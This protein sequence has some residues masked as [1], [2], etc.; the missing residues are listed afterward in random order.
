MLRFTPKGLSFII[1]VTPEEEKYRTFQI[2]KKDGG[3][4]TIKAPTKQLSLL[5]YRLSLLLTDCAREIAERNPRFQSASHGFSKGRTIVSNAKPHQ[6][7]RYVFNIDIEEFF[8]SINFGRV[9]GFFI[10]DRNFTLSPEVATVIA[11][12]VCHENAL[13]QGS[14]CSPIISNLVANI[15]DAR[16]LKLAKQEHCTYTRYADDLTFST[17]ERLFPQRIARELAGAKWEPGPSLT[18]IIEETGF[19]LNPAKTRMSL[20]RSRQT[21]TGLVVNTKPNIRQD[22]Y[23]TVRAIC[24]SVF[25]TGQ[26]NRQASDSSIRPTPL[27]SLRPIE[28]ML[29]HIYF[30]KARQDRSQKMNKDANFNPP[31]GLIEIYRRFLFYKHFVCGTQPLIITEGISD[32]TYLKCA[33]R[34]RASTFPSLVTMKD[35]KALPKVAFLTPS[36]TSR[37][38]L[39][40]GNGTSGQNK[41]INDYDSRLK[42]Y[43]HLPLTHP[44]IILCDNDDGPKEVFRSARKKS[45]KDVSTTTTDAF[46]HLGKNLYLIKVPEGSPP[47]MCDIENLFSSS[48]LS[49]LIDGKPFDKKK[50]H[51]DHSA[52]GK[53]TFA[54]RVV[55]P[56][57]KAIDFSQFD[58]L[59]KRIE[60]CILDYAAKRTPTV[61]L[62]ATS[63]S[64]T[65][66]PPRSA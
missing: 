64:G 1:Y 41:L 51:G 63:L 17:N 30:V 2:K 21:V 44:V 46:Y 19:R 5:Q 28:G 52:Y 54:D 12:I 50:E 25:K 29:S 9:R 56:N 61:I 53:V 40:L 66:T 59:L 22:Y 26:W 48:T 47:G 58:G 8:G 62:P 6:R 15:L 32:I 43:K 4:R 35:G 20:R 14:P 49:T 65:A 3:S 57:A 7:R 42:K 33:I 36:G 13:P 10:K 39:D 23:R 27:D 60:A 45:A 31:K 18:Q 16:L 37:T 11:Q 24:D 34:A 38:L 55:R